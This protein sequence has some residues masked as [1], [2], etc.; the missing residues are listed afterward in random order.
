MAQLELK[1][2]TSLNILSLP[3]S[4]NPKTPNLIIIKASDTNNTIVADNRHQ[5]FKFLST[6]NTLKNY[7]LLEVEG[8]DIKNVNISEFYKNRVY[9]E[10]N[11]KNDIELETG[12]LTA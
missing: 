2:I 10:I 6:S 4:N 9:P 7:Y 5:V 3:V 1:D 11:N 8:I 12:C